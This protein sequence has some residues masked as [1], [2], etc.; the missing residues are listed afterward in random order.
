M[1]KCRYL[2]LPKTQQ[3]QEKKAGVQ[4]FAEA[5]AGRVAFTCMLWHPEQKVMYCGLTAADGDLLY[6]LDVANDEF[7]SMGFDRLAEKHD[8]K[9]H[10]SMELDDDG[11][12]YSATAC[13]HNERQRLEAP[14]GRI[15][16]FTPSTG[17]IEILARPVEYDYI[18]TISLDRKRRIIYG[19]TYPVFKFFRYD[20]D[21][22]ATRNFD[23]MGSITH[24]SAIDDDGC[25]WGTWGRR[26]HCLFKY[27]PDEDRITWFDHG[28]LPRGQG[29]SVMYP[30]AG[31]VDVMLNCGD[32]HLYVGTTTGELL[33]LDPRTAQLKYLGKAY[34]GLRMPCLMLGNDGLLYGAGGS[35]GD[36]YFFSYDRD[37]ERFEQLGIIQDEKS[38]EKCVRV[39]DM[40]QVPDGRFYIG[41][42]D[43]PKRTAYL[44]EC[45]L[46]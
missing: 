29:D 27:S 15:F 28:V 20:I 23:Y 16:R 26:A 41:E 1:L 34:P 36:C 24:I 5:G 8:V 37:K 19:F 10:R 6:S 21:A 30:G 44:W 42:T 43:V 11:T 22:N 7:T 4:E 38:G 32:G 46:C 18:Q 35:D 40:C 17:Q 45:T 3:P 13:L 25:I 9:L 33:R 12:V 39:H 2:A 14:G 31:P